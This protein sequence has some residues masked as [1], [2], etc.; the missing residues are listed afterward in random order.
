MLFR[1][2]DEID[3]WCR[4][5][6]RERGAV[7]SL[8]QVWELSKRWYHDRMSPD[9]RGKSVAEALATFRKLDLTDDFWLVP[10]V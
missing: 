3:G 6:R 10:P 8:S 2:E 9:F 4:S 1:S 7:L 5:A